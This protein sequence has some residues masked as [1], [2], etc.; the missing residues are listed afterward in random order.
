[1]NVFLFFNLAENLFV[2]SSLETQNVDNI[3]ALMTHECRSVTG[4]G[5]ET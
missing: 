1:M 4:F 2:C 3:F 5:A